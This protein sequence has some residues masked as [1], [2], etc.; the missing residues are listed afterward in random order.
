M[1]VVWVIILLSPHK[2]I[3]IIDPLPA[4]IFR[5]VYQIIINP[6]MDNR[7]KYFSFTPITA[8]LLG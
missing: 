6:I 2:N 3:V 5:D 8:T 7:I 4:L 1:G